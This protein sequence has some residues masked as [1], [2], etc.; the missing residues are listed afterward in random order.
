LLFSNAIR[1]NQTKEKYQ[2]RSGVFF[3]FIALPKVSL[4][5]RCKI[6][7]KDSQENVIYPLNTDF[8]FILY[9]KERLQRYEIDVSTIRNYLKPIKLLFSMNDINV[10]W[11]KVPTGFA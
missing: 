8:Q 1:S 5:E 7:L 11:R 10:N 4:E 3:D 9:Q 2:G 6:F